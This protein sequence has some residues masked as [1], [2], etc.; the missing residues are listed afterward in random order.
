MG[1]GQKSVQNVLLPLL[2]QTL[3]RNF[4]TQTSVRTFCNKTLRNQTLTKPVTTFLNCN[5][6]NFS[7]LIFLRAADLY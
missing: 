3:A 5:F 6:P 1:K 4:S 2:Q 7:D